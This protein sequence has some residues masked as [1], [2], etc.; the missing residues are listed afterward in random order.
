MGDLRRSTIV[1]PL[2]SGAQVDQDDPMTE[3]IAKAARTYEAWRISPADSNRLAFIFDP[4]AD[5]ATF[6]AAV[7]IFDEGGRTPPNTHGVGQE[8]F[9]VLQGNGRATCDGRVIEVGPGDSLLLKPGTVHALENTGPGRLYCLTIMV[10]DDGFSTLIRSG[11][12][13]A[14]DAEDLAV[15]G[16]VARSGL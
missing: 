7:E 6:I 11:V 1:G 3:A 10:P 5:G 14:L 15:L 2:R 12:R 8:M 4:V 9:F 16:R 13:A